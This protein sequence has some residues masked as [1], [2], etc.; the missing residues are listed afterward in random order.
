MRPEELKSLLRRQPFVPLRFHITD[1]RTY[2]IR[3]PDQV[4]VLK[5]A[6]DIGVNPDP[7]S[8]IVEQV[9]RCSLF[10]LVRVEEMPLAPSTSQTNG[11]AS[12]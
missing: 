12:A 1:G 7:R 5:G 9:E 6:V 8:G 3:H 11:A 10:H 2:D 4:I